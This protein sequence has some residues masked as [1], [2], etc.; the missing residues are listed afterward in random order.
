[1]FFAAPH[2]EEVQFLYAFST[3][4]PA[5]AYLEGNSGL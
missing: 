3:A 1:M 4:S 2:S 5:Y